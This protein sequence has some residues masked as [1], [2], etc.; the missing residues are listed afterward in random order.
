VPFTSDLPGQD[1]WSLLHSGYRPVEMVMGSC[2]DHLAD[3]GMLSCPASAAAT[4]SSRISPL[5]CTRRAT[6]IERMQFEAAAAKAEGVVGVDLH[7]G[8][9]G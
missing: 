5:P 7:D 9:Y 8:S 6:S 2:V 3:R 1:F 4:L